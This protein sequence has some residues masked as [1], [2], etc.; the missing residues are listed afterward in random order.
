MSRILGICV[1]FTLFSGCVGSDALYD[2]PGGKGFW[3]RKSDLTT[4]T[5][6]FYRVTSL[7]VAESNNAQ[8]YVET[9]R[10]VTT[11]AVDG[12]IS[13]FENSIVPIEHVWYT[14]P[15]DVDGNGKIIFLLLD[16]QDGYQPGG[17][18]IAGYFDPYN[19]YSDA[20]VNA[21][22][23][24]Y[25]SNQAEM[26]YLDTYPSDAT[27]ISFKATLAHE[28]QHLLQFSKARRENQSDYEAIWV[29]EG[30][31]EISSDLTG[32][33]PQ[34]GRANNFRSALLNNTPLVTDSS[35]SFLLDN[36]ATS[37]IYFRYLA[38]V[39]GVGGIS[40]IFNES[41][42]GVVGV[43]RALQSIDSG[44]TGTGVC[45]NSAAMAYPY[46]GCSYRFMWGALIKGAI[47][48]A[49]TGALVHYNGGGDSNLG[50]AAAYTYS[51]KTQNSAYSQE[52]ATTLAN[53]SY[54]AANN[55]I[56]GALKSY[57]PKLFKKDTDGIEP[58]FGVCS[59]CGITMVVGNTY[60]VTFN[61]DTSSTTT[62]AATVTDNTTA[63]L[64]LD[65]AAIP[66]QP[67]ESRAMHWHFN[68]SAST[69]ELLE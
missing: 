52:L 9:G 13:A 50:A 68:I 57:A 36:Y 51:M 15:S 32:F 1:V 62:H 60:Y 63:Q 66:S 58:A 12:L 14:T 44:L 8:V 28:Y 54:A 33:G 69:L 31:A 48:D 56:T 16:I 3:A 25:H 18:Y 37:Y 40:A 11:A 46:F 39:Y 35:A 24:T 23:S 42:T 6:S 41:S 20:S 22:N 45:G 7:F 59:A 67:L 17:A 53:G 55:G 47:G 27:K 4:G 38:D 2:P 49:P 5:S 21:T 26:L 64:Q 43:N 30:L 10:D 34:T 29:D 61:H 19:Y 65:P